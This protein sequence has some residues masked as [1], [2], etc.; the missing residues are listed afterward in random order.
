M[1]K[2]LAVL[3]ESEL[4]R[5]EAC[6]SVIESGLRE[7]IEVGSALLEIRETGL[8]REYGTFEQYCSRRW[9]F[10]RRRAY[11][12]MEAAC[13]VNQIRDS[14]L[15]P[16]ENERQVRPLADL[17]PEERVEAWGDV[18]E[19][20]KGDRISGRFVEDV[21]AERQDLSDGPSGFPVPPGTPICQGGVPV[22]QVPGEPDE[23]GLDDPDEGEDVEVE[24]NVGEA[25]A[26]EMVEVP[27]FHEL[28][29]RGALQGMVRDVFD[30][31]VELFRAVRVLVELFGH[32]VRKI[33]RQYD[34]RGAYH[35]AVRNFLAIRKP[36]KWVVCPPEEVGGCGGYG[37]VLNG[38]RCPACKG[39]GYRLNGVA[40]Q[41]QIMLLK[42][43]GLP[44][45]AEI[46]PGTATEVIDDMLNGDAG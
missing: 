35:V 24:E 40:T 3:S 33:L 12:L 1:G 13:V 37:Y 17:P 4:E 39:R 26:G 2:E 28:P 15:S 27:W 23:P 31:D 14:G 45:G 20:A 44:M 7:F 8:Y 16:P 25:P 41:K 46:D 9:G 21:I 42:R 10:A 30:S 32:D 38:K 18:I 19:K 34:K 43:L 6:E 11:Q 22:L 36:E 5:L 29:V